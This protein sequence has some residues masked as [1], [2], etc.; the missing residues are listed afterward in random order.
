MATTR[1]RLSSTT[2]HA[3]AGQQQDVD[4]GF[5]QR[6]YVGRRL[7][8]RNAS[9]RGAPRIR[10]LTGTRGS[11]VK[12]IVRRTLLR[13]TCTCLPA[14]M[15]ALSVAFRTTTPRLITSWRTDKSDH[16]VGNSV[17]HRSA[18]AVWPAWLGA[19]GHAA[20]VQLVR[21]L[22][23]EGKEGAAVRQGVE[24]RRGSIA[25]RRCLCRPASA[26]T[27]SP[28]STTTAPATSNTKPKWPSA[29]AIATS[30]LSVR[31]PRVTTSSPTLSECLL[32][33]A[34]TTP[35][36]TPENTSQAGI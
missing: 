11:T 24:Q 3:E 25:Q 30:E 21:G 14:R 6:R 9:D 15:F 13:P 2:P 31:L 34:P 18:P 22:G 7:R 19:H 32:R 23:S 26:I 16:V 27:T 1:P 8:Y 35:I 5:E 28:A 20:L 29:T 4:L 12:S 10:K 36:A 33:L 17:Q